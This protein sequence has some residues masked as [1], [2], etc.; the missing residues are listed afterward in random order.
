MIDFIGSKYGPMLA[1]G[2]VLALVVLLIIYYK[3]RTYRPFEASRE[4]AENIIKST[5]G[6][7]ES[8][9]AFKT[10]TKTG[11]AVEFRIAQNLAKNGQLSVDSLTQGLLPYDGFYSGA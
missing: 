1:V 6:K 2:V 11:D 5:G 9:G 4:R 3:P 10:A 8:F 7:V